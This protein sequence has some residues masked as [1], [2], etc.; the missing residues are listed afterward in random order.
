MD[1]NL[2]KNL[3]VKFPSEKILELKETQFIDHG[4]INY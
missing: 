4:N 3:E 1:L 2:L